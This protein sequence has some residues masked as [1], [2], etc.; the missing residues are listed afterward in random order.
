M[1]TTSAPLTTC[2]SMRSI[3]RVKPPW[4]RPAELP[5][6]R[7]RIVRR[8]CNAA[9]TFGS[10]DSVTISVEPLWHSGENGAGTGV[11][12]GGAGVTSPKAAPTIN[13]AV[14]RPATAAPTILI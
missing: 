10:G 5:I 3:W 1:I 2:L 12:A 14:K 6:A 9:A 4:R 13:D 11:A 7:M 8:F